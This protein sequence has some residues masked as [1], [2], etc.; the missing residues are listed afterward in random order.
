V[1]PTVPAS[2]AVDAAMAT[3]ASLLG[4]EVVFLGGLTD[5]T[6]TFERVHARGDWPGVEE[7]ASTDRSA[8]FC[9]RMLGGAPAATAD[10]PADPHYASATI[11]Q[12]LGIR[13]YVG[14][15]VRDT[16]GR[17]VATLCGI[18]RG[19]V[20]VD[21]RTLEVLQHLA[22]VL[23]AH[24]GPL[25]AEGVVIRRLPEGGWA[26][27]DAETTSSAD[28]LTS[29][30]VLADLLAAEIS[31]GSRPPR[32]EGELDEVGQL[33]LSVQQLEHAL[34]A[35]VVVEQAIGVLTERLHAGP[36]DAFERLRRTARSRGRKVHDLAR[37]VVMSS[38][39]PAV[40]LPPELAPR[41]RAV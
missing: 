15:P 27:G 13:S 10:A 29:A 3:A 1:T 21:D 34:A 32:A 12:E 41:R 16:T 39:N 30:M 19:S 24:V 40:P 14:V 22:D 18:D 26:V 20:P 38:T 9:H 35:R 33:R 36:R 11:G 17:V 4:M 28:D 8:T 2:P 7:G 6:F 5:D 25:V 31:P 37:E 23:S